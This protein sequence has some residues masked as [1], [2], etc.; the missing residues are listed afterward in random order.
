MDA[1]EVVNAEELSKL[2]DPFKERLIAI[3]REQAPDLV[4]R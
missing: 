3:A 4:S 2:R 1:F